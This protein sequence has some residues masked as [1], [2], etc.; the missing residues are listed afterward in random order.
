MLQFQK[1]SSA[2]SIRTGSLEKEKRSLVRLCSGSLHLNRSILFTGGAIDV[3]VFCSS[4]L[5]LKP[6]GSPNLPPLNSFTTKPSFSSE[7]V[8]QRPRTGPCSFRRTAS[9]ASKLGAQSSNLI[10][11]FCPWFSPECQIG[12]ERSLNIN[13]FCFGTVVSCGSINSQSQSFEG[14][15]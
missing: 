3:S 8:E 14:I 10:W 4:R 9:L 1:S 13:C 11:L 6:T 5:H 12:P 15:Y 2:C 7:T